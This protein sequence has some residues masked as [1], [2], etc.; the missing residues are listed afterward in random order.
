MECQKHNASNSLYPNLIHEC[1]DPESKKHLAAYFCEGCF[2]HKECI[3]SANVQQYLEIS[4]TLHHEKL[5]YECENFLRNNNMCRRLSLEPRSRNEA[6]R[7]QLMF[8]GNREDRSSRPLDLHLYDCRKNFQKTCRIPE[9]SNVGVGCAVCC[10]QDNG[11][12]APHVY[13]SGGGKCSGDVYH[14]DIVMNK[15]K[16]CSKRLVKGRSHHCMTCVQNKLYV[17]GGQCSKGET[18]RTVEEFAPKRHSW[19]TVGNLEI[20]VR[21]ATAVIHNSQIYVFGGILDM[22][23]ETSI[24][25]M[26]DPKTKTSKILA[27]LPFPVSGGQAVVREGKIFV[28]CGNG[29]LVSYDPASDQHVICTNM[30]VCCT[31]FAM[32]AEREGIFFAGGKTPNDD[33][34]LKTVYVY[35]P[36][37]CTW[38]VTDKDLSVPLSVYGSCSVEIPADYG[39]VPFFS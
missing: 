7:Y 18:I 3:N 33:N 34:V 10:L 11:Y 8:T 21:S 6:S 32:F 17:L 20:G 9:L 12:D 23:K 1:L 15:R 27:S 13:V 28:T 24:V 29:R 39:L 37:N 19:K 36:E 38:H 14:C 35:S 16:K 4:R 22:G 30:P 5:Q 25:Q 2:S 26:F 31:N